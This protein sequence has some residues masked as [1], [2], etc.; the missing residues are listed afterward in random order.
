[1]STTTGKER[2]AR[3]GHVY[4]PRS[5][6]F[7]PDARNIVSVGPKGVYLWGAL[8]GEALGTLVS[9][10]ADKRVN[11]GLRA[12]WRVGAVPHEG[13]TA[14][15]WDVRKRRVVRELPAVD[16]N[17]YLMEVGPGDSLA[18]TASGFIKACGPPGRPAWRALN[19]VE[20]I[21]SLALS[22]DGKW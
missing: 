7:L 22:R 9:F 1:W 2:G 20:Q 13:K 15:C 16:F 8:T 4:G 19:K 10:K 21:Y 6:A 18:M 12:G 14:T 17:A 11:V 3:T 5:V